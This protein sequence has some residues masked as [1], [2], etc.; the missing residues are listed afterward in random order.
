[1]VDDSNEHMLSV[2]DCSRGTKLAEIKVRG[3]GGLTGHGVGAPRWADCRQRQTSL[4]RYL[5]S[6][7]SPGGEV[8]R[9]DLMGDNEFSFRVMNH[10][11][12]G[13]LLLGDQ[14]LGGRVVLRFLQRVR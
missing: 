5:L 8:E 12:L 11:R 2:W 9:L 6:G 1:M 13:V 7:G 3:P 14:D 10:E 4:S